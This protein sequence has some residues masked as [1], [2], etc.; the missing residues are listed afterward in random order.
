MSSSLDPR[1]PAK[2][3]IGAIL[4]AGLAAGQALAGQADE[5]SKLFGPRVQAN[6]RF[7]APFATGD[8]DGDGK[9]DALY[10]VTILP[11]SAGD[12]FASDV[13]VIGS[14][15]GQEALGARPEALALAIVQ[16]GGRKKFLL[17]GYE[18]DGVADYFAS[19][20]WGEPSVPIQV[21]K[22]GSKAFEDFRQQD[23]KIRNDIIV[24]GTEAGIDTALFWTGLSY[25]LFQPAEEP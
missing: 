19:P 2:R 16:D 24:V 18:G 10:L 6:S 1:R 9:P 17:T 7:K 21:A 13:S 22:R 5:V 3:A 23:G 11:G 12:G 8:F 20:I 25:A 15:F 14:L 4:L